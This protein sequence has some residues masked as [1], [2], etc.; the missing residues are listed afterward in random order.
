M[1]QLVDQQPLPPAPGLYRCPFLFNG[2]AEV[3]AGVFSSQG[4]AQDWI[5]AGYLY[6]LIELPGL[7]F[8]R[9]RR[10]SLKL[11]RQLI[12]LSISSP[13]YLEFQPHYW[14]QDWQLELWAKV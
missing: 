11:D 12:E 7:D 8:V 10:V 6:Q 5:R 3:I 1:W 2:V 9:V 14:V 4:Q 13:Y